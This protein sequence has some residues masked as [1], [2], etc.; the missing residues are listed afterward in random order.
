MP[1]PEWS[2]GSL[3]EYI[4]KVFE[5]LD[6]RVEQR[7]KAQEEALRLLAE[8]QKEYKKDNNEHRGTLNDVLNNKAN[9]LE[10]VGRFEA[11]EKRIDAIDLWRSSVG[12]RDEARG[13][14]KGDWRWL[15]GVALGA[16]ALI[17]SFFK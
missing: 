2:V 17:F 3:R 16:A 8:T 9:R 1:D 10:M 14:N 15:I 11:D 6:K 7:F 5:E 13:Q 12:G 4:E